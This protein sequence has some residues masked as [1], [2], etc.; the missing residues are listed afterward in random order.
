MAKE[1][2][3]AHKNIGS[4][5]LVRNRQMLLDRTIILPKHTNF[6]AFVV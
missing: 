4:E 3:F 2:R 5:K 1:G 6:S